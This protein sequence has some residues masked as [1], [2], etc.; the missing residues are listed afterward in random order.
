MARSRSSWVFVLG[1]ALLS[2]LAPACAS[3]ETT[4][5]EELEASDDEIV[6]TFDRTGKID[7]NKTTR[8]LLI[9]DSSHLGELPLWSATTRARRYAQL[10]PND[11][12]VLFVTKDVK[13][14][15]VTRTASTIVRQEPFGGGLALSDF[16]R[17][18]STKLIA[19]LDRFKRIAT[20][21]F[22]GHSSPFNALLEAEGDN[23]TLGT[24]PP[25]N[26]AVLKDNFARDVNPYVT[27]NGCNGA[28]NVA[29]LLSKLWELPVSGALTGSNF[30]EL[31]S[32]GRWYFNDE[33]FFPETTTRATKNDKSFPGGYAPSCGGGACVRMKPQDSPYRGVWANPDTG[34]QYGAGYYKFFCDYADQGNTCVKGMAASLYAFASIKHIDRRSPDADVKEVLADFFCNGSKDP[35]WFDTCRTNLFEAAAARTPF[36]PMRVANDYTHECDMKSCEQKLRCKN[37]PATNTPMKKTCVWVSAACRDDQPAS[38]CK[39]KNTKKQM[40]NVELAK[41]LEGHRLLRGN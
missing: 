2:V 1:A 6:A 39:V 37:D 27:L 11:Q 19:A 20:L 23:R 34:F 7:L 31:R 8:I 28:A 40:T 36:S 18:D 9:G 15:Q 10:Y 38:Q 29:P 12:V 13:D 21:E 26:L 24:Q 35:T 17:L 16:S 30:Q 22:F 14:A 41:Y 4:G 33:G 32:D 5:E 25:A 3:E